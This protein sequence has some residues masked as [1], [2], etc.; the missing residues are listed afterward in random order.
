MVHCDYLNFKPEADFLANRT[1]MVTGA[2]DGI[3]REAAIHYASYGARVILCGRNRQKLTLVQQQINSLQKV[4]AEIAV[5]D[6]STASAK[7]CQHF[8]GSI[9]ARNPQIDG[10]L[11]SAGI[12]GNIASLQQTAPQ[13]WREVMQ[14]NLDSIFY[15]TQS[16]IPL[17]T[18]SPSASLIFSTSSVGRTGKAGWG[19]YAVS[20]FATEGMMQVLA[21][22]MQQQKYPVRVNC[23]NPGATRTQM[24]A[25]AY[26]QEDPLTLRTPQQIMPL[27]LWLM[28]EQSQSVTGQSL[29]AQPDRQ[30][31]R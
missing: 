10:V 17:L 9:A 23:I 16:L 20:K 6:L 14:I 29:D 18:V 13:L 22:E 2:S 25:S 4:P 24:R 3:G 31:S 7:D 28:S 21:D 11:H 12:L 1:L 5:L 26:P 30:Q 27:Y 8:I 19:A 15:L